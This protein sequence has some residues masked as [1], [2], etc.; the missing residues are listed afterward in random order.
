M[1]Y[2]VHMCELEERLFQKLQVFFDKKMVYKK[3]VLS[4]S[5]S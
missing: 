2:S 4:C 5:K 3:E 1:S